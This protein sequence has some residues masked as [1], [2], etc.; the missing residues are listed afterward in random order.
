MRRVMH[1]TR[2]ARAEVPA[3]FV[4]IGVRGQGAAMQRD[5]RSRERGSLTGQ[6]HEGQ[7]DQTNADESHLSVANV[8]EGASRATTIDE[9]VDAPLVHA[10]TTPSAATASDG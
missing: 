7:R 4:E 2:L 9:D 5:R 6:D 8:D 10:A 1:R 3:A